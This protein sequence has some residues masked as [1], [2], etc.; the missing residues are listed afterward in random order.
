VQFAQESPRQPRRRW[1]KALKLNR[2]KL[3]MTIIGRFGRSIG[4]N[5]SDSNGK[6]KKVPYG[7]KSVYNI[8]QGCG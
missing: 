8:F 4:E 2:M 5:T 6:P 3:K 7:K 1:L